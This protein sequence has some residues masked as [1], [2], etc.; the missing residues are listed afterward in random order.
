MKPLLGGKSVP[1]PNSNLKQREMVNKIK[2]N[3]EKPI[4]RVIENIQIKPPRKEDKTL[5]KIEDKDN[6]DKET[7]MEWEDN[8][9]D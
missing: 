1:I 3:E 9:T 6:V 8:G 7:N 5:G 4:I 2:E